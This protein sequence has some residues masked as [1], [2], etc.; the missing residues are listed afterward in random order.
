[1]T[2]FGI[3]EYPRL[4][5]KWQEAFTLWGDIADSP[6]EPSRVQLRVTGLYKNGV[7]L[8]TYTQLKAFGP[9]TMG[10]RG[11]MNKRF[12]TQWGTEMC[13]STEAE[14]GKY[15]I[16][17]TCDWYDGNEQLRQRDTTA[18]IELLGHL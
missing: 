14:P 13:F 9:T 18:E 15:K 2:R 8:D 1:M 4:P 12:W 6:N 11:T 10:S 16:E 5:V 17:L 7:S 3:T